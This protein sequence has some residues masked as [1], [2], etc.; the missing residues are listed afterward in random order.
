M[1]FSKL[2]I[3][4]DNA[5]A[6]EESV[7]AVRNLF[8]KKNGFIAREEF[9]DYGC[10][11]E[12][13]LI[14]NMEEAS[15]KKFPIQI[16][17]SFDVKFIWIE[18]EY[19][20]KSF[21]T[22]RLYYL[23]QRPPAYGIIIFYDEKDKTCYYDYA[24]QVVTRIM[25]EKNNENWKEQGNVSIHIPKKN[26]LNAEVVQTIH[27]RL[28]N[29]FQA[30]ELLVNKHGK[31]FE[32]PS[33][34]FGPEIAKEENIA[35]LPVVDLLKKYGLL[36]INTSELL[37]LYELLGQVSMRET[38]QSKE[39]IFLASVV[40]GEMGKCIEAEFYLTKAFRILNQFDD[41]QR[42]ILQFISIKIDFLFG[43][44]NKKAFVEDLK[45][46]AATAKNKFNVLQLTINLLYY[47]I[48]EQIESNKLD[49]ILE[50]NILQ[51]FTEIEH[52]D[53]EVEKKMFLKVFHAENLHMYI[54]SRMLN[55][56]SR[57]RV[58]EALKIHVPQ[59][60]RNS[61]Y[62]K[63]NALI[64]TATLNVLD[65]RGY[66]KKEKNKLLQA[67][68]EYALARFERKMGTWKNIRGNV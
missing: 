31:D 47:G 66:A 15:G 8:S 55:W 6:S 24:E 25:A 40:Y 57:L 51:V 18:M 20:T 35:N 43:K 62:L 14:I 7:L 32:I 17:S 64:Y 13:E 28:T 22:S 56:T 42:E 61:M 41:Q 54:S 67:H 11:L 38:L 59:D 19:L 63:S 53:I 50:Q 60:D 26:V 4:D 68:A 12:V 30:Q 2:P 65:A 46:M 44:R 3:V 16:K 34:S 21:K 48:I 33:F 5:K 37:T 27:E 52:T 39:L 9:P 36:F 29:R 45:N 58:K 49:D 1:A 23:C 10:D